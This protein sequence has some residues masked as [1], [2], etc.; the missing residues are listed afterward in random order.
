MSSNRSNTQEK[1]T[2]VAE[3]S[4]INEG[5]RKVVPFGN[6]ELGVYRMKGKL[7]AYQNLCA[8][9]GGPACEG[10]MMPKVEE[11]I[12]QDKTY[13]RMRFNYDEW[14]IVCPWHGWEYDLTTG[15][16][17]VN[18]KIRLK[19]FEVVEKSGKIYIL[20]G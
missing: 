12:A 5:E 1:E 16:F 17:V 11:V 2:F 15:E 8:H 20:T 13:Q 10:L 19:K 6:T 3:S 4:E 7:Y 9:Q 14:H 18:R